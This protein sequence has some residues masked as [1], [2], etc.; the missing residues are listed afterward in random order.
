MSSPPVLPQVSVKDGS[1]ASALGAGDQFEWVYPSPQVGPNPAQLSGC[2]GFCTQNTFVVAMGGSTPAQIKS[3][4]LPGSHAFTDSAW[5]VPGMP[6]INT[7][8]VSPKQ[9]EHDKKDVA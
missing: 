9:H 5:D 8:S 3:S 2:S 4:T 6:H 1:G 7:G